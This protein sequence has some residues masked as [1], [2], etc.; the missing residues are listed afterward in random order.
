MALGALQLV[1]LVLVGVVCAS[2]GANVGLGRNKT[3]V[4][5]VLGDVGLSVGI[6]AS[7]GLARAATWV[8]FKPERF[9]PGRVGACLLA[10]QSGVSGLRSRHTHVHQS[11]KQ[12]KPEWRTRCV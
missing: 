9:R 8:S 5:L 10:L 4:T 11:V 2:D 12:V 1:V 3:D 6:S 7:G